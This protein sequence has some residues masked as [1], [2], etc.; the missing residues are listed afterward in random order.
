MSILI[1]EAVLGCG[2]MLT[3]APFDDWWHNAYGLDVRI[4]SP[5]HILLGYGM[6]GIIL[7]A[8]LRTLA[9][10]GVAVGLLLLAQV[11]GP[12]GYHTLGWV[13]A[14]FV[15]YGFPHRYSR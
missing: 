14:G 8:L 3:S 11:T 9:I 12:P 2:A 15:P 1:V 10:A 5:P 7:G 13:G 4:V 6:L